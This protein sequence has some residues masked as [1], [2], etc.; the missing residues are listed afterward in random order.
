MGF[1]SGQIENLCY[2]SYCGKLP[3]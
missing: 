2:R 1:Y 3:Q